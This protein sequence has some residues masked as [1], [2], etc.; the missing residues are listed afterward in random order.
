MSQGTTRT[1][2]P[3]AAPATPQAGISSSVREDPMSTGSIATAEPTTGLAAAL[4]AVQAAIPSVHKDKVAVVEHKNGRGRH[5]YRFVDLADVTA[6]ILPLLGRHGLCWITKPTMRDGRFLLEY[7]L[8][9]SSG[10]EECGEYPLPAGGTPQE[11]GSAITYARRYCLCCVTGVAPDDDDDAA[12]AE[13]AAREPAL[14]AVPGQLQ[15]LQRCFKKLGR[16]DP[17]VQLKWLR[18]SARRQISSPEALTVEEANAAIE[19]LNAKIRESAR[20][21]S[22]PPA[23]SSATQAKPVSAPPAGQPGPDQRQI[24]R[25]FA[26][27]R[28]LGISDRDQRLKI[29]SDY[30]KRPVTSTNDLTSRD[31]ETII[32]VFEEMR[33]T[34]KADRQ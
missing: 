34:R 6:A 13:N 5:S 1:T 29:Y 27:C 32:S 4:A 28:E 7:K 18:C 21:V 15:A 25:L 2:R 11:T 3:A 23:D 20:P 31:A 19:E 24:R 26:L 33:N 9:H 10:E 17:D 30:L 22:A 8:K 12:A 14:T 16:T